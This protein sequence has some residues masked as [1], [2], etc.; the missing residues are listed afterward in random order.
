MH[1]CV[2]ARV[3]VHDCISHIAHSDIPRGGCHGSNQSA[4]R[5]S[6]HDFTMMPVYRVVCRTRAINGV[7]ALRT[8]G[9]LPAYDSTMRRMQ[10][11][12]CTS[13]A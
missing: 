11:T 8:T 1:A 6:G 5:I 12:T 4:M 3:S 10:N 2:R 7:W 9:L 13:G